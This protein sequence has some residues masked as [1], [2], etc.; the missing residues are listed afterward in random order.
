MVCFVTLAVGVLCLGACAPVEA[1]PSPTAPKAVTAPRVVFL[2]QKPQHVD[3][4]LDTADEM[5]LASPREASEVRVLV[6]GE[7]VDRLMADSPLAPRLAQAAARGVVVV[8]CGITLQRKHMSADDLAPSVKP[9]PNALRE[10]VRL[11]T[12]GFLSVEL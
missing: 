9:V 5:L 12:M 2:V 1:T 10:A 7:G 4:A 11:Q 8:A 3:V 6:C